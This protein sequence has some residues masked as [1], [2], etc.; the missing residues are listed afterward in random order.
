MNR[1]TEKR[2]LIGHYQAPTEAA[3]RILNGVASSPG[4]SHLAGYLSVR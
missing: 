4:M 2:I 3:A 1:A